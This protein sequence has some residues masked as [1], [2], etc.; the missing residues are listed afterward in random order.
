[1]KRSKLFLGLT[2]CAVAVAGVVAA[3]ANYFGSTAAY[4]IN[5]LGQCVAATAPCNKITSGQTCRTGTSIST[6]PY[7]TKTVSGVCT[8]VLHYNVQ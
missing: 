6:K 7:Y 8:N 2:T 4:R 5:T 1:M 3:K